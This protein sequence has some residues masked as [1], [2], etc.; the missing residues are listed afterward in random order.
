MLSVKTKM[1]RGRGRGYAA[2]AKQK[3]IKVF[4]RGD[5]LRVCILYYFVVQ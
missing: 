5:G 2:P 1:P 4:L 3:E